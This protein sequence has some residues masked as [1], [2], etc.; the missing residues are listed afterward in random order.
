MPVSFHT[1]ATLATATHYL[2]RQVYFNEHLLMLL[3]ELVVGSND[4]SQDKL[5]R[6]Y[7]TSELFHEPIP[8]A[9]IGK[10][11]EDLFQFLTSKHMVPA[12][13]FVPPALLCASTLPA[14][15][16]SF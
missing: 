1:L 15:I 13:S 10:T 5:R 3:Q 6:I 11:Y 4:P 9:L 8:D 12:L 14:L 7:Q 16:L 2:A